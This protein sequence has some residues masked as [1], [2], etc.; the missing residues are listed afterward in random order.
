L[1]GSI[2]LHMCVPK[3]RL[4]LKSYT[5][6]AHTD[7]WSCIQ[8]IYIKCYMNISILVD[9]NLP[10]LYTSIFFI[11]LCN[12]HYTSSLWHTLHILIPSNIW[13]HIWNT[14]YITHIRRHT[15]SPHPPNSPSPVQVAY[16]HQPG[17]LTFIKVCNYLF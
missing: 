3:Q 13:Y 15:I 16:R 8:H 17:T 14:Q 2:H 6:N 11:H 4:N 10:L 12:I 9:Y 1:S 5:N 7:V